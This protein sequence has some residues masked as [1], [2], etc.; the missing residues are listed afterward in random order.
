MRAQLD[1]LSLQVSFTSLH[2][3]VSTLTNI[4]SLTGMASLIV[5]DRILGQDRSEKL[6][7]RFE[8]AL[9]EEFTEPDGRILAVRNETTG[10]TVSFFAKFS[11][12][13]MN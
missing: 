5:S 10:L 4:N 9:E 13:A 2:Q 12:M 3:N 1:L 11:I 6:K 7:P 8:R